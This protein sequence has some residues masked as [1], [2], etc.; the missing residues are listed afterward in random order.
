MAERRGVAS[1]HEH[2]MAC[3]DGGRRGPG[4][5]GGR[6][7]VPVTMPQVDRDRDLVQ[8]EALWPRVQR[9]LINQP[10]RPRADHRLG[11]VRDDQRA[12]CRVSQHIRRKRQAH[13][14]PR[15]RPP[16]PS[17]RPDRQAE[18]QRRDQLHQPRRLPCQP[19]EHPVAHGHRA[20]FPWPAD[21]RHAADHQGCRHPRRDQRRACQ[22]VA[23]SGRQSEHSE[24]VQAETV[25]DGEH[26]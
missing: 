8:P 10:A 26:I 4:Q 24:P 20:P 17:Q 6:A 7:H 2:R 25:S 9:Q 23:P 3:G 13:V 18:Q 11:Q 15:G 16:R 22:R 12:H 14:L 19:V 1:R 5:C 21:R